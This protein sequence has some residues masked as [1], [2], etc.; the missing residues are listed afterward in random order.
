MCLSR[1]TDLRF[2]FSLNGVI[3]THLVHALSLDTG[4]RYLC[5]FGV[6][7]DTRLVCHRY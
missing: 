3:D 7:T 2:V 1:G 4:A 5:A 6:G